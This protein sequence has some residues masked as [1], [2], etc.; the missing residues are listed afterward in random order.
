ML[1]LYFM[2]YV[3]STVS[4]PFG[5]ANWHKERVWLKA[6]YQPFEPHS[7]ACVLR[8]KISYEHRALAHSFFY[9]RHHIFATSFC[10]S[11][12]FVCFSILHNGVLKYIVILEEQ[13]DAVYSRGRIGLLST[14]DD[15][16]LLKI[17]LLTHKNHCKLVYCAM[18]H[19]MYDNFLYWNR[20][21]SI[22][23][24]LFFP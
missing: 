18:L 1:Y 12:F 7:G 19:L 9:S 3:Y 8:T 21:L 2:Y 24:S 13:A 16:L 5:M 11:F 22:D 23:I 17:C 15:I 20:T 10:G 4:W 14:Q 6:K